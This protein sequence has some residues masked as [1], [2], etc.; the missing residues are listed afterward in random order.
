MASKL[1]GLGP[2]TFISYAFGNTL[3]TPL[4]Q[5]LTDAGFQ[6]TLVVDTSLLCEQS[7]AQAL[8]RLIEESELVV[9]IL[10]SKANTSTWVRYELA[11][12]QRYGRVIMPIVQDEKSLPDAARDIPYLTERTLDALV[13]AVM[14]RY[15]LLPLD[16]RAPYQLASEPL[17]EYLQSDANFIRVILDADDYSGELLGSTSTIVEQATKEQPE[18][19][20]AI[21]AQVRR[22]LERCIR[23]M[24]RTQPLLPRFRSAVQQALQRYGP[25]RPDRSMAPWQRMARLMV[26]TE[27]L[28][29][30]STLPASTFPEY[31]NF[32]AISIDNEFKKLRS[33]PPHPSHNGLS[34][35]A[36]EWDGDEAVDGWLDVYFQTAEG[37][38][39][40]GYIPKTQFIADAIQ[41]RERPES[42]FEPYQWADFGLPQLL[43]R[44]VL[45]A[46]RFSEDAFVDAMAWNLSEY[47]SAGPP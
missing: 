12:A 8:E 45:L 37:D 22:P 39:F 27:W 6:V 5:Q 31:W 7:L 32:A 30:A 47:Q 15:A 11:I 4:A 13:P 18:L 16:P 29:I 41:V 46:D 2:K 20:A 17:R 43:Q 26:G 40:R 33:I 10:D 14:S 19:K 9:P 42:F 35:W 36:L 38:D 21:E 28:T 44:A 34:I 24:D 1:R 3:A 25:D 23:G